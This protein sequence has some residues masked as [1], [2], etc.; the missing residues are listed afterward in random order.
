M[1]PVI[2]GNHVI[3]GVSGD[4]LDIPG[5]LES[6]DPETG[7]LQWHWYT[8][9]QARRSGFRNWPT[10]DA[11]KHGGGMTLAIATTTIPSLNMIYVPTGNPQP[12]IAG[13]PAAGAESLHRLRRRAESRY[14]QDA[15]VFP[16]LSPHDTHDWDATQTPVLFDGEIN[17]QKRKLLAQASRNGYF[18]VM[19][20]AT[21]KTS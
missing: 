7:N 1:A 12:V 5:Y 8:V 11:M 6:R 10:G 2:V 3:A 14:R 17:G 4:D 16:S 13:R 9:P 21:G 20:R 18:F 15:M 19:D